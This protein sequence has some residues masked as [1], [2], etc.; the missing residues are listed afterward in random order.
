[1]FGALNSHLHTH[2]FACLPAFEA[3]L[4][5][6]CL[7]LQRTC[8]VPNPANIATAAPGQTY[9]TLLYCS[10]TLAAG[11]SLCVDTDAKFGG[12]IHIEALPDQQQVVVLNSSTGTGQDYAGLCCAGLCC[13]VLCCAVLCCVREDMQYNSRRLLWTYHAQVKTPVQIG[14]T[15]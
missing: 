4:V 14:T 3:V 13:A 2:S 6:V 9:T 5:C 10:K 12:P 7:L 11:T 1:M 8:L 15:R